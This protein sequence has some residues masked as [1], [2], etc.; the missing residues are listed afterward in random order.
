MMADGFGTLAPGADPYDAE[1]QA[2]LKYVLEKEAA[3][4]A[5]QRS[6]YDTINE[7]AHLPHR[8]FGAL[9]SS[10]SSPEDQAAADQGA[11][12]PE[13]FVNPLIKNT[14]DM[15]GS[16]IK[17]GFTLPHDVMT[18]QAQIFDE[19]G[20]PTQEGIGRV[21]DMS[22]L[23]GGASVAGTATKAS[24]LAAPYHA[25]IEKPVATLASDTGKPGGMIANADQLRELANQR[26]AAG[27]AT[28]KSA[29]GWDFKRPDPE[30]GTPE[31]AAAEA[32]AA[33]PVE[34]TP[35]SPLLSPEDQ[36]FIAGGG[37][38]S[39]T[40]KPGA[41]IKAAQHAQP[42]YSGL[43]R[44]VA[45]VK[46]PVMTG[47]QWLGTLANKGGVKAE[48]LDWSGAKQLLEQNADRSVSKPDLLEHLQQNGVKVNEVNKGDLKFDEKSPYA[49]PEVIRAAR[50]SGESPGE[51]EM[52]LAND[53]NAY[54]ALTKKFPELSGDEDWAGKVAR[55]VFGG[56]T[57]PTGTTKYHAYQLPGGENYREKLL[58]LEPKKPEANPDVV[59]KHAAAMDAID[60]YLHAN[61][62]ATL[63]DP[64]YRSLVT[65]RDRLGTEMS[66]QDVPTYRSSH[67]DEP[68][69]LVHLRMNDREMA[70]PQTAED[71]AAAEKHRSAQWA[72]DTN[73]RHQGDMARAIRE[74]AKPLEEARVDRM[75][76]KFKAGEINRAQYNQSLSNFEDHPELKPLQD[77]LQ[78]LRAEEDSLRKAAPEPPAPRSAKALHLEEIQS[79]WHQA[80]RKQ[81]YASPDGS[82]PDGYFTASRSD[83]NIG[84]Y[85]KQGQEVAFGVNEK[86]AIQSAFHHIPTVPDAPFK[87][88]WHELG[89]KRALHEAAAGGYDRLSWTPGEAQAA[90]YDL[91]KHIKKITADPVRGGDGELRYHI[92]A[93]DHSGREVLRKMVKTPDEAA[94]FIG[95][96][97]AEKL[98]SGENK[99][100][101]DAGIGSKLEGLDLK[102][103][104]E[105]MKGFYDKIVP[106][107]LNKVG[108]PHGVQ[109]KEGMISSGLRTTDKRTGKLMPAY[110]NAV[111]YIEITPS[112]RQ[113]ILKGMPLFEDSAPAGG[114][115]AAAGHTSDLAKPYHGL[116]EKQEEQ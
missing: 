45:D 106:D 79:D 90:R 62:G 33:I 93:D 107:Y 51:L 115:I 72:I 65:A 81:G 53:G 58:T 50:E 6:W 37:F 28:G 8:I 16:A 26:R 42:F 40:G 88:N 1:A 48:E 25:L 68:N 11:M 96:E 36:A 3:D 78:A 4:K 80:G 39:D 24:E 100:R 9:A 44:A 32:R 84:V 97:A 27:W 29:P 85:N 110:P 74:T 64:E 76:Q 47:K 2:G 105:G 69:V 71:A 75:Y 56:D 94:E 86:S 92:L 23:A 17:S 101:L 95:K 10:P 109:V 43:E 98:F 22:A 49:L 34:P 60:D 116:L 99:E 87:K 18:G 91:S 57:M 7:A 41:A 103:G 82:L 21:L 63:R 54:R 59:A 70:L 12:S 19:T 61:P 30:A 89:L 52:T 20:H 108:K 46:Q 35:P 111:H 15:V 102:V 114:A 67:W 55:S 38:Y 112:L 104:G 13:T 73:R 113:H 5:S 31:R 66:K 83:G 14:A 77:K